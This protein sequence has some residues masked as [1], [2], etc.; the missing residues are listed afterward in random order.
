MNI[1]YYRG[2]IRTA[3]A[4]IAAYD[5]MTTA[6]SNLVTNLNGCSTKLGAAGSIINTKLVNDKGPLDNGK[7]SEIAGSLSDCASKLSGISVSIG[8]AK[9]ALANQINAWERDI[10]SFEGEEE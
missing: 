6:I 10:E 7:I 5:S 1:D 3:E 9:Q 4:K 8:T 2:L